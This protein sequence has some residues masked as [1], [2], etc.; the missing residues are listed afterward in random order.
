MDPALSAEETRAIPVSR[1]AKGDSDVATEKLNARGKKEDA[2]STG[3]GDQD[4]GSQGTVVRAPVV[5]T[6]KT[7][8][9]AHRICCAAR[10]PVVVRAAGTD[11]RNCPPLR[12]KPAGMKSR[13]FVP[14]RRG[15]GLP[16][17]APGTESALITAMALLS[18]RSR[19]ATGTEVAQSRAPLSET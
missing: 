10:A 18:A 5:R 15:T 9:S 8:P 11:T 12:D 2:E 7:S 19:R 16:R 6:P 14:D 17:V 1:P 4:T 13:A 3:T